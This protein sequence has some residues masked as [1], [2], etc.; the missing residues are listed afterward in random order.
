MNVLGTLSKVKIPPGIAESPDD[1][2]DEWMGID[3]EEI[4]NNFEISFHSDGHEMFSYIT[5]HVRLVPMMIWENDGYRKGIDAIAFKG[6]IVGFRIDTSHLN[7]Y[8]GFCFVDNNTRYELRDFLIEWANMVQK[9]V[10]LNILV[11]PDAIWD[12]Q[13]IAKK[14]QPMYVRPEIIELFETKI[15]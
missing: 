4:L 8:C 10:A 6:T 3:P 14:V 15:F 5:R 11:A 13:N 7:G 9:Q 12:L 1:C 2:T